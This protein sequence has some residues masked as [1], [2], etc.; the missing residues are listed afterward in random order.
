MQSF[1]I[2]ILEGFKASQLKEKYILDNILLITVSK[3]SQTFC[4]AGVLLFAKFHFTFC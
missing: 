2:Q 3:S 4:A 1:L